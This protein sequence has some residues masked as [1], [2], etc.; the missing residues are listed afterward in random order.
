MYAIC[1]CIVGCIGVI[2]RRWGRTGF[3]GQTSMHLAAAPCSFCYCCCSCS[4]SVAAWAAA[5]SCPFVALDETNASSYTLL[6]IHSLRGR[7]HVHKC[8]TSSP[9]IIVFCLFLF[10]LYLVSALSGV[11]RPRVRSLYFHLHCGRGLVFVSVMC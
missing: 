8:L 1:A 7:R 11:L 10:V 5:R 6:S 4:L 9:S 2:M 3:S